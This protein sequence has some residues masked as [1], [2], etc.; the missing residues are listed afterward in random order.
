[1]LTVV[2]PT[3]WPAPAEEVEYWLRTREREA[4]WLI[5]TALRHNLGRRFLEPDQFLAT[6]GQLVY[7]GWSSWV[8]VNRTTDARA[9]VHD[10][11]DVLAILVK[12]GL[13]HAPVDWQMPHVATTHATEVF[14]R[15]CEEMHRNGELKWE[16]GILLEVWDKLTSS[17]NSTAN[18][19]I[20][21]VEFKIALESWKSGGAR[22][23][24][25]F[26]KKSVDPIDIDRIFQTS[27]WEGL[28]RPD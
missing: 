24:R 12:S 13:A 16:K 2:D 22:S 25:A 17:S 21:D 1:M 27:I 18:G 3:S 11:A 23:S 15:A 10:A 20:E 7:F 5:G 14:W 28:F 4:E 19:W 9:D 8:A 26:S 6:L